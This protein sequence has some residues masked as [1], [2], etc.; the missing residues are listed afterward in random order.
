VTNEQVLDEASALRALLRQATKKIEAM[1]Q[2]NASLRA[3]CAAVVFDVDKAG[4]VSSSTME[5]LRAAGE[6]R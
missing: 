2:E 4:R 6:K 5:R 3:V 1:E